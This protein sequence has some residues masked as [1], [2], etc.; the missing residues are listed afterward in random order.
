MQQRSR[1]ALWLVLTMVTMTTSSAASSATA[2][3]SPAAAATTLPQSFD[4]VD[5]SFASE[6]DVVVGGLRLRLL[7]A[8]PVDGERVLLLHC[9]GLSSQV[10]REVMPALAR[11]GYRVA[12][13]DAPG[14][15]K[16]DR[17]V[18]GL[19]VDGLG[20]TAV[21]V[22]DVLGWP[23]AHLV[24]SSMGGATA[25]TVSIT[26]PARV[27][28]MVLV[29]AAGLDLQAWYKPLW[30]LLDT[31]HAAYGADW[32]WATAFDLAVEKHHP[33]GE[34]VT[35]ELLS[36][37]NDPQ[38]ERAASA[39]ISV[40]N[41]MLVL[42]RT[43]LLPRVKAHTLVVTGSHDRLVHPD[44]AARL[45][46]GITGAVSI[47]YDDLGHLPQIEDPDRLSADVVTFLRAP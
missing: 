18:Q 42:D 25:L 38:K 40:V 2:D 15:G 39:F 22:L 6:R 30:L 41:N 46:K 31:H 24:G 14:H 11:A 3:Q 43:P 12:A 36:T 19:T 1:R 34:R 29:D 23:R 33:L 10:W 5:Y 9:F 32:L 16:S 4:E 7:E 20:R 21:S 35:R 13:Y 28:R 8:G 27:D 17:P 26:D 37:R 47:T 44:H 45:A